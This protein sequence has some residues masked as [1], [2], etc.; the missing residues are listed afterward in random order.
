MTSRKSPKSAGAKSGLRKP[1]IGKGGT[2]KPGAMRL[3]AAKPPPKPMGGRATLRDV[4]DA[5]GVS[6]M[7]VSNLVNGRLDAMRPETRR[8][9]EAQIEKLGYRP[10]TMARSLRLAKRLSIGMVIVDDMPNYL[11]DPFITHVVSGLGNHL[12]ANGYGLLLQGHSAAAFKSSPMVRDIRTDAICVMLSGS[13]AIRRGV[14]ETLLGLGQPIVLFQETLKFPGVDLCS[15]RQ[16]DRA[17]GRMLG[18]VALEG[19]AKHLVMLVPELFWPAIGERIKGIR[20]ALRQ[21]GGK[22]EL[23]IVTCGDG[24]FRGT[25]AALAQD[26]DQ[27]GLPDAILA[28]NDQMGISAMKLLAAR[29]IRIPDQVIITGFNAF[30]FWQYTDPV[31]TTV[32]SPAYEIGARGGAEILKRLVQGSFAQTDIVYPVEL[33]RGGST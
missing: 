26:L 17:G 8:R 32:H 12:N 28:G 31:L 5:A 18:Q 19:G 21:G 29:G 9:I 27:H 6:P 13:D 23:R 22:A 2:A 10:H 33:Q 25:Q 7:T 20:E 4:A 11:A 3:P 16:D 15:I 30:E 14:V 1:A 24:E